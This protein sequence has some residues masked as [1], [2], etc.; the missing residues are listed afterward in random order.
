MI[1]VDPRSIESQIPFADLPLDVVA[2]RDVVG[3]VLDGDWDLHPRPLSEHPVVM[4]ILERFEDGGDWSRTSLYRIARRGLEE[5][6]PLWKFRTTDDLPRLFSKIDALYTSISSE[7][8]RTQANLGTHRLWDELLVAIDR[9]GAI[10]LID[11]AHRLAVAQVLSLDSVPALVGVRHSRWDRLRSRLL[12]RNREDTT[13]TAP[14][15]DR[16]HP[17]LEVVRRR[18]RPA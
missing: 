7:G 14:C 11:G 17:D 10:H 12:R 15:P 13:E 2:I 4:G 5:G 6:R 8:Y 1:R 3:W 16:R 18:N 9:R